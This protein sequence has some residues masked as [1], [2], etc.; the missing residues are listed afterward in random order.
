MALKAAHAYWATQ[1][2]RYAQRVFAIAEA[3]SKTNVEWG[4]HW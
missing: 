1:D 4:L 3:W 2:M